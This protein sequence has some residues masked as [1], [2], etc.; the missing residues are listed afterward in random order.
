MQ[1]SDIIDGLEEIQNQ[2]LE[3]TNEQD[4]QR[5]CALSIELAKHIERLD[6]EVRN[7]QRGIQ[8]DNF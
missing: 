8:Q 3:H 7:I 4:V 2:K 6:G 5:V 1:I